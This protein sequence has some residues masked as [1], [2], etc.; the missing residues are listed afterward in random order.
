MSVVETSPG[1]DK[2]ALPSLENRE[3]GAQVTRNPGHGSDGDVVVIGAGLAGLAAA[4]HLRNRGRHPVVFEA[5]D[6]IGGRQ[7]SSELGGTVVEE[8]AVFFGSQYPNLWRW[9]RD[10]GLDSELKTYDAARMR[11]LEAQRNGIP[12]RSWRLLAGTPLAALK[13][14]LPGRE[15]LR[16]LRTV[17]EIA[18]RSGQLRRMLGNDVSAP[19]LCRLDEV[20]ASRWFEDKVGPRFTSAL[21]SPLVESLSF[22]DATEWSALGAL[23]LMAFSATPKLNAIL[24]GNDRIAK[25]IADVLDVRTGTLATGIFPDARGVTVELATGSSSSKL[26]F[27][28]AVVAVPGPVAASLLHGELAEAIAAIRYSSSVVPVIVT[29]SPL[30]VPAVS[31]YEDDANNPISGLTIERPLLDRPI[32]CFANVRSPWREDVLEGSDD[33]AVKLLTDVIER[34]TGVCPV[35]KAS[36]VIRWRNSIPVGEPG[37]LGRQKRIRELATGVAHLEPAGDYLVSPSQEG[38]LVSGLRAADSVLEGR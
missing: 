11:P 30:D 10:F 32:L 16:L 20:T 3:L 2:H 12:Q 18:P 7:R 21:A 27:R 37:M 1:R 29:E 15:K 33:D 25:G 4:R 26:R 24:G 5:T 19:W 31:F 35:P 22:A 17:A 14:E 28:D 38:A 36:K 8:G 9:I 13:R 34:G 23:M 6:R